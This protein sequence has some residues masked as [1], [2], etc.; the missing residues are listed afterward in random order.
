MPCKP[1]GDPHAPAIA[2]G[3][4]PR[5]ALVTN[6][7]CPMATCKR[8]P[9]RC[10][11]MLQKEGMPWTPIPYHFLVAARAGAFRTAG[12][13]QKLINTTLPC[14]PSGAPHAPAISCGQTPSIALVANSRCPMAACKRA[15][16]RCKHVLQ[17]S[18]ALDTPSCPSWP[19][20]LE[21]AF[22]ACPSGHEPRSSK[23]DGSQDVKHE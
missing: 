1:S 8:A 3:Q 14:K 4:T 7:R 19:R 23:R 6:S 11:H 17:Q 21:S 2:C 10:K 13:R 20:V 15:P 16:S 9:S 5:N 12:V 22:M 18:N